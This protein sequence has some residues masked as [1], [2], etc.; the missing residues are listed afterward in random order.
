MKAILF[1]LLF[2]FC[3]FSAS[4]AQVTVVDVN[5]NE[6]DIQYCSLVGFQKFLSNKIIVNINYGQPRKFFGK[7]QLVKG[8]DGK[9]QVFN[10]MIDAL[11]FMDQN[12]WDY[13]NNYV[14]TTNNQSVYHYLLRK[15]EN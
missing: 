1:S 15:R 10:S 5:I 11:N 2:S 12:G 8:K 9:N 3:T 7:A 6:M 4:Q 13:V 14:V